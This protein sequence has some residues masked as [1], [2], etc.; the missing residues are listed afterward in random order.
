M[1]RSLQIVL[2][3]LCL[4]V[5]SCA[6]SEPERPAITTEVTPDRRDLHSYSNPGQIKVTHLD[7]DLEVLFDRKVLKGTA[8]MKLERAADFGPLPLILDTRGLRIEKVDA[9][10]DGTAF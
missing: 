10:I 6:R 9:S 2:I 7:L 5:A 4:T 8:T 1:M 3:I